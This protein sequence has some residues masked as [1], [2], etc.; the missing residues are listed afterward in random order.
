MKTILTLLAVFVFSG[1]ATADY[2][3]DYGWEDTATLLGMYPLECYIDDL[4]TTPPGPVHTGDQA[5]YVEKTISGTPQGFVGWVVGLV[6]GDQVTVNLWFYDDSPSGYPSGRIWAHWNDDPNDPAA[7]NGSASG[8]G[9]Y[10]SGIGW[11]EL[12]Y[13][14]TVA[15]GHTGIIIEARVYGDSASVC[16]LDD[17]SITAPD[18]A[19]IRFPGYV[20]ALQRSTWADIKASF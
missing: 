8:N 16:H 4:V 7:Y 12:S 18:L 5:L 6:D 14:W 15:S 3:L 9:T 10:T 20:V 13:T 1:I 17:I 11:E 19:E 2:T